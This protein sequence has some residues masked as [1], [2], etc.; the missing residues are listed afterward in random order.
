MVWQLA[1]F[2]VQVLISEFIVLQ[3]Y[4]FLR[5]ETSHPDLNIHRARIIYPLMTTHTYYFSKA[6]AYPRTQLLQ[7]LALMWQGILQLL[8]VFLP[9]TEGGGGGRDI[10]NLAYHVHC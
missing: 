5:Q 10:Y 4:R 8:W 9:T 1:C 3:Y 7:R 6:T 2:V